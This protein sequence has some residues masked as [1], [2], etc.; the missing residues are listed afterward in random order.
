MNKL[1]SRNPVQRFKQ[2]RKIVKAQE[3]LYFRSPNDSNVWINRN[4]KKAYKS[5]RW[6][7]IDPNNHSHNFDQYFEEYDDRPTTFKSQGKIYVRQGDTYFNVDA[8]GH[9]ISQVSNPQFN[10]V[11]DASGNMRT[12]I[13]KVNPV[14]KQQIDVPIDRGQA[15]EKDIII[16]NNKN[17]KTPKN[18]KIEYD[19]FVNN[20]STNQKAWLTN[21]GVKYDNVKA[22]QEFLNTKGFGNKG[23]QGLDGK[24][25]SRSQDAWNKF[26]ASIDF[27][28]KVDIQPEQIEKNRQA[29]I[30]KV[31]PK[32]ILPTIP[33]GGISN[34][35]PLST[36]KTYNRA[37]IRDYI[38]SKGFNPY[39][40]AGY[41]RKALRMVMNGQGTDEDRAIVKAMG[42]FKQG[43]LLPSRNIIKRFKNRKFN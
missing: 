17:K 25:G 1:I 5:K 23:T 12:L 35:K 30:N 13:K 43:G 37:G 32:P 33:Q 22:L 34:F 2:G 8:Q 24:W 28:P 27:T 26:I 15:V 19:N 11:R 20:L 40:Y 38:R 31:L 39:D 10:W 21:Q 14:I 42:I 36:A 16:T 4:T 41:Q 29:I 9:P 18:W 7:D 6:S 3:G